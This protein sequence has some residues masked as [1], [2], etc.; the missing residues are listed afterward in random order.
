MKSNLKALIPVMIGFFTMGFADL[1]GIAT[2]YIKSD[3]GLTETMAGLLPSMLFIWFFV[4]SIPT[5][6]MMNHIGRRKTVL[7]SLVVTII[8][9]AL[10]L[11]YYNF[12]IMLLSFALLGTGN[13]FIQVSINPLLSNIVRGD[14]LAS[15]LTFGQ[16]VK[17]I[18]SFI[19]PIIA[20][21]GAMQ[22]GNWKIL[23]PIFIGIALI[24]TVWLWSV[25]IE[26]EE[27]S[28]SSSFSDCFKLLGRMPI[29]FAFIGIVCHVGI[30]VGIN[31]TAPKILMDRLSIPLSEAGLATSVYFLFRTIGSFSGTFILTKISRRSFFIFSVILMVIGIGLLMSVSD[32]YSIYAAIGVLGFA[33]SNV[34][35]IIMTEAISAEPNNKNE[36]SGILITGL[37]GGSIF[38]LLM[39]IASDAMDSLLGALIVMMIGIGY[40]SLYALK[41]KRA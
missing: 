39:G 21:W 26:E 15:S 20:G 23:F 12:Y 32:M 9:M 17:A 38:P 29:L 25:N 28:K 36:V 7:L 1:V 4:F 27:G 35:P 2:N 30:D 34:F 40:L 3:F 22:F 19:A 33:N 37:I 13:T 24:A 31:I 16:F 6:I 11:V 18:A 41:T 5:G 8:A 10:P 14:R